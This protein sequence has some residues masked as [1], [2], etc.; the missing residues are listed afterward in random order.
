MGKI[1]ESFKDGKRDGP[2]VEYRDNGRIKEKG[3]YKDGMKDGPW[4]T[5]HDNG[6]LWFKGT[7]KDGK[8]DGPWINYNKDGTVH[9]SLT[10]TYKDGVKV[11]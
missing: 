11:K 1:Q 10:G 6:Q 3:T 4:V 5:Y 7:V 2:W 9:E 8:P